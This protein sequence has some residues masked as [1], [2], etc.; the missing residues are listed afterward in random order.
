MWNE[1][2]PKSIAIDL[3]R[4]RMK[5]QIKRGD[6]GEYQAGGGDENTPTEVE[7][8]NERNDEAVQAA[9]Q[10]KKRESIPKKL[11]I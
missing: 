11:P 5:E 1:D 7:R 3:D 6:G 2:F 8:E 4:R 9:G 10:P